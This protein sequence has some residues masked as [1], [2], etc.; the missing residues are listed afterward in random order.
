MENLRKTYGK[1][2]KSDGTPLKNADEKPTE[3]TC[4]T[5]WK[6]MEHPWKVD[7]K[8]IET[9]GKPWKSYGTQ[10]EN[11]RKTDG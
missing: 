5:R 8:P 6:Q 9:Y 2:W 10:M 4:K 3:N 11:R 1:S 7:G